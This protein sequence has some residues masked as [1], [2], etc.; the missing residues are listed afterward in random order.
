MLVVMAGEEVEALHQGQHVHL[1]PLL[2][3][4]EVHAEDV[5]L[6]LLLGG[7]TCLKATCLI[8]PR[9]LYVRFVVSRIAISCCIISRF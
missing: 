2:D 3:P 7:I 8:R 5:V 1:L 9:S 6:H 4:G